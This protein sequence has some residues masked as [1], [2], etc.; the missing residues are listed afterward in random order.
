[1]ELSHE[2][3]NVENFSLIRGCFLEQSSLLEMLEEKKYNCVFYSELWLHE[4]KCLLGPAK[5]AKEM[6]FVLKKYTKHYYEL[7]SAEIFGERDSRG[8]KEKHKQGG[9]TRGKNF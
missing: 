8:G 7:L 1:M 9:K 4:D 2:Q 3:K 5:E 6:L